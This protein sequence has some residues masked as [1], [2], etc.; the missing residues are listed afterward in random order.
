M[1]MI[2]ITVSY[3]GWMCHGSHYKAP[4]CVHAVWNIVYTGYGL[5]THIEHSFKSY[6]VNL[7]TT[8]LM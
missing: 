8:P 5:D 4:F 2:S 6:S 3:G 1:E 7:S